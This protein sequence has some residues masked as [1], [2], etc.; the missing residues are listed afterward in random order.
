MNLLRQV[1][2][3]ISSDRQ[4]CRHNRN[5]MHHAA[6]Q[7]VNNLDYNQHKIHKPME[8]HFAR[9][10]LWK[11]GLKQRIILTDNNLHRSMIMSHLHRLENNNAIKLIVCQ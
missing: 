6:W 9:L 8:T 2:R 11:L 7:V 1:F 10:L 4:T 3:K 5:Y